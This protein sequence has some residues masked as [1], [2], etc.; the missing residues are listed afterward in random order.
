M[1]T[2]SKLLAVILIFGN[3]ALAEDTERNLS[4]LEAFNKVAGGV[5]MI[6]MAVSIV[7]LATKR[8]N[9]REYYRPVHRPYRRPHHR[10]VYSPCQRHREYCG[11]RVGHRW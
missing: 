11:H 2:I 10:P 8:D 4:E 1:K 9:H 5:M 3:T 7:H 6:A